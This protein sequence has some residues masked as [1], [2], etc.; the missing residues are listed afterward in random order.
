MGLTLPPIWR[1]TIAAALVLAALA[2]LWSIHDVLYPFVIAGILVYILNPAV[3]WLSSRAIRGRP[4]GRLGAVLLVVLGATLV[5]GG[6]AAFILPRFYGDIVRLAREAPAFVRDFEGRTL[7]T[8]LQLAQGTFDQFGFPIDARERVYEAARGFLKLSEEQTV[9]LPHHLRNLIGGVFSAIVSVVLVFMLTFFILLD[10]PRLKTY[11]TSLLPE[12][13]RATVI[14]LERDVDRGISGAI[15]GQLLVCLV[16][17]VL[18]TIGL[19]ILNIK[20]AV[21]I[22]L[23]AGVFSLIPIFGTI[24][25][26]IPAALMGLSQ[27]LLVMVEVIAMIMVIHLIE[28]NFL[29][30]KIVGHQ[31]ELHPVLVILALLVGEHFGGA[32]GLLLAVPVAAVV[33]ALLRFVWRILL[34][35]PE[36]V[37]EPAA[38]PTSEL[39]Q[40]VSAAP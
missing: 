32:L 10:V 33:R 39:A 25:S 22:G 17:A 2:F 19:L 12:R 29:N 37:A 40:R 15:R 14:A 36:P 18:T 11:A 35:G 1:R 23:I 5:V 13:Y 28:A 20:Y 24:L 7:P 27:S 34:A 30:P 8:W 31:A 26:T 16:N 38:E 4:V 3:D 6:L 21:T 9:A